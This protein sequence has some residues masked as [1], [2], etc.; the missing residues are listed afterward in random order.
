M[1]DSDF[2]DEVK[3]IEEAEFWQILFLPRFFYK[4][5]YFKNYD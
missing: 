4:G 1:V 5:T 2:M 3:K